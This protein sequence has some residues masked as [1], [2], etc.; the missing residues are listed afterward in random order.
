MLLV[1]EYGSDDGDS[2]QNQ[3]ENGVFSSSPPISHFIPQLH[4]STSLGSSAAASSAELSTSMSLVVPTLS[5]YPLTKL[6]SSSSL[7]KY[8]QKELLT[9]PTLDV[10]LAPSHGPAHPYR[11]NAV[12]GSGIQQVGMGQIEE[13]AME[14]WAFDDQYQTY[15]RN[16]YA[17]DPNN[18]SILGDVNAY[19]LATHGD[20][21]RA[22]KGQFSSVCVCVSLSL[23][24][25]VSL[26]LSL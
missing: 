22:A 17:I 14:D 6:S 1:E 4:P 24:H 12:T 26:S 15:L 11:F 3:E 16:G 5:T 7:I 21:A 2:E 8:N 10:V 18:N 25:S 23:S 19:I 9:N 20:S 13:A